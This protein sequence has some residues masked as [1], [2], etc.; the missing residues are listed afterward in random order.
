MEGRMKL[1]HGILVLCL[2]VG[3]SQSSSQK[4]NVPHGY[5]EWGL[6]TFRDTTGYQTKYPPFPPQEEWVRIFFDWNRTGD[7][8]KGWLIVD[9]DGRWRVF[10]EKDRSI[11]RPADMRYNPNESYQYGRRQ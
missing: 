5:I 9:E 8:T 1:W 6:S 3:C 4:D 7:L 2:V 11:F 10:E